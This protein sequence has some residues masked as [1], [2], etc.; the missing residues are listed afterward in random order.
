[1]TG[2]VVNE[3]VNVPRSFVRQ[4]SAMLNAWEVY[5]PADAEREFHL[6]YDSRDR[7][8][9]KARPSFRQVVKGKLDYLAMVRGKDD[10]IYRRLLLWYAGLDPDYDVRSAEKMGP[11][12][13]TRFEDAILVLDD[14]D[15]EVQGTGFVLSGYGLV[16]CDHV[17]RDSTFAFHP[18]RPGVQ[19]KL[20]V[21]TRD[22]TVDL[23]VL[24]I[25]GWKG[26]ALE[27]ASGP[28]PKRGDVV[29]LT[30]FPAYA[31]GASLHVAQAVVAA[32]RLRM[33]ASRFQISTPIVG[34]ASGAPVL[35]AYRR[36]IGVA[37]TGAE[38]PEEAHRTVDYGVIPIGSL[39]LLPA[40]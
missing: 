8:P 6:R 11:N 27:P 4:L 34:G 21:L 15:A 22:R 3:F 35:D 40:P 10:P 13:L 28:P 31:R 33:D 38:I 26:H 9:F 25:A 17:V 23:A 5:G 7:A 36:V 18:S 29:T 19:Y 12:H 24:Q 30:G 16:T 39:A 37:A 32:H 20:R 1:V 14:A 2:L